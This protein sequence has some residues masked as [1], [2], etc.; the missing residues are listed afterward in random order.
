[1]IKRRRKRQDFT[2]A[3]NLAI[4]RC[5]EGDKNAYRELVDRYQRRAVSIAYGYVHNTDDAQDMVQEAFIR[6]YKNLNRFEPGSSFIAWFS[7]IVVNVCIDHYRKQKKR[8]SVE[9][10]DSY[11]RRDAIDGHA[12]AGNPIELQ[13]HRRL[14][15]EELSGAIEQA[16]S[17][18]SENHRTIIVLREVEGLSYE[19]IA[20][21]MSCNLGTV[22]SRLH[23]ARK[24]LQEALRPYLNSAGEE[25][26]A[27]RAGEGVGTKR[28][29]LT[30]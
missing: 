9:Y 26:L 11:Q 4:Q 5:L 22:M 18:L 25:E 17:R 15:Q 6:A 29:P 23:H 8:K 10:D 2:E 16:L 12:L 20:E 27:Q 14:E 28:N 13:P 24:K 30:S 21:S 19:E 7:K 1:M 3:D